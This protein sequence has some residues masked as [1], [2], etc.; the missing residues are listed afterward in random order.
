MTITGGNEFPQGRGGLLDLKRHAKATW[1]RGVRGNHKA[2]LWT[3][4]VPAFSAYKYLLYLQYLLRPYTIMLRS[5]Q[6]LGSYF[7]VLH[8]GFLLFWSVLGVWKHP[9]GY[10]LI[11]RAL[12]LGIYIQPLGFWKQPLRPSK[13][14]L[15]GMN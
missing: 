11:M 10:L 12:L 1:A 9:L 15:K 3:S 4:S 8:E 14:D 6:Q 5:F 2:R 13:T 7:G